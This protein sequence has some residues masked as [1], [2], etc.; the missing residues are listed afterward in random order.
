MLQLTQKLKDGAM[1]ALEVHEP[2]LGQGMIL[3]R[4][5]YSLDS[6]GSE[7]ST[8]LGVQKSL[9]GKIQGRPRQAKQAL[10]ALVGYVCV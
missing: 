4:N 10:N 5:H 9:I 1:E 3:V 8:V 7:S 6:T 2:L